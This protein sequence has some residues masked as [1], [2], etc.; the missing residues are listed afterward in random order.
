MFASV[1]ANIQFIG[2]KDDSGLQVAMHVSLQ[3]SIKSR[4]FWIVF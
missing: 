4:N 1:L 2:S 3:S